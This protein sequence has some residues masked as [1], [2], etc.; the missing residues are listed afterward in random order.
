MAKYKTTVSPSIFTLSMTFDTLFQ[1]TVQF[2]I[3]RWSFGAAKIVVSF[4]MHYVSL[5]CSKS[6]LQ[7]DA[8][9]TI[10]Y[11]TL[12]DFW[13]LIFLKD[14]ATTHNSLIHLRKLQVSQVRFSVYLLA[15]WW[16]GPLRCPWAGRC[17]SSEWWC[18]HHETCS[19]SSPCWCSAQT[20]RCCPQKWSYHEGA[21]EP[22]VRWVCTGVMVL[23]LIYPLKV[24]F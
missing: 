10:F 13:K 2:V 23:Q 1:H 17:C 6:L 21:G 8:V 20:S 18:C 4:Y 15:V 11:R 12:E 7:S 19:S 22:G 3:L 16:D 9:I 5:V 24:L 14:T